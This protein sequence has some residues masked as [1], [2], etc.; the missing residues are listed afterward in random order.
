MTPEQSAMSEITVENT[1][2][3]VSLDRKKRNNA[4][5]QRAFR[6]RRRVIRQA[7]KRLY[8]SQRRSA[9]TNCSASGTLLRDVGREKVSAQ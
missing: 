9:I 4:E 5:R 8:Q 7:A 3:D 1:A 6:A 2:L